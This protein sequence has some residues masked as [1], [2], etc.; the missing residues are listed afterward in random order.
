MSAITFRNLPDETDRALKLRPARTGRSTE[1]KIRDILEDAIPPKEQ[2]NRIRPR[3]CRASDH[4][5][6]NADQ[7]RNF[8]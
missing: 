7:T 6:C 1:A 5:R 3:V 8:E 2:M 4:A